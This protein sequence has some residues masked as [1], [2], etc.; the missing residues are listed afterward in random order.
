MSEDFAAAIANG[1]QPL[2]EFHDANNPLLG[3]PETEGN[4]D[5]EFDDDASG[6]DDD[7]DADYANSDIQN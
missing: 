1:E 7:V 2:Q 3:D 5:L 4:P 6:N